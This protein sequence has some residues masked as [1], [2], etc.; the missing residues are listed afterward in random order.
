MKTRFGPFTLDLDTRQLL[1]GKREI[2]LAPKAFE[3]L[4]T[5][6]AERPA[7]LSKA[8][9]LERLWPG[10][11]VVDANVSN[12]VAEI[13]EALDARASGGRPGAR[14]DRVRPELLRRTLSRR[15]CFGCAVTVA[16]ADELGFLTGPERA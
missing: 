6:V 14:P 13:R 9:L 10:S 4:S 11:F 15:T 8:T 2:H 1:D 16:S 12:L 3:L 5:L 7:V